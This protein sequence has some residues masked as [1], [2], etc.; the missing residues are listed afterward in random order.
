MNPTSNRWPSEHYQNEEEPLAISDLTIENRLDRISVYGSVQLTRD[1]AGLQH[2]KAL[3]ELLDAVVAALES[4]KALPDH[5]PTKPT[6]KSK[7]PSA[8]CRSEQVRFNMQNLLTGLVGSKVVIVTIPREDIERHNVAPAL[9]SLSKLTESR[10]ALESS[11]GT[12]TLLVSGYDNDPRELHLIP[13]VRR[14][15]QALDQQF[16]F[17]FHICVRIEHSL[18]MIF[19]MLADLEPIALEQPAG[20]IGYSISNDDLNTFVGLHLEAMRGLHVKYGF[21]PMESDRTANLEENYFTTLIA[22]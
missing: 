22:G 16:P 4:E 18:R 10:Q 11:N 2:A 1:K 5:V 14:Y 17:W 8:E 9:A 15:F 20:A 3:K 19:T 21:D 12:I 13:E 6:K 7:I